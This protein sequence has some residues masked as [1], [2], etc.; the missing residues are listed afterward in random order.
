[1]DVHT[2]NFV[3]YDSHLEDVLG[4]AFAQSDTIWVVAGDR[5]SDPVQVYLPE[6]PLLTVLVIPTRQC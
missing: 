2:G 3:C 6:S 5:V 1:M 4:S